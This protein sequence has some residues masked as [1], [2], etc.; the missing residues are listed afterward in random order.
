MISFVKLMLPLTKFMSFTN[1]TNLAGIFPLLSLPPAAGLD[2][3]EEE[4]LLAPRG[5]A[6][7]RLLL[8]P[9]A[10]CELG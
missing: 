1:L 7:D 8:C 2:A 5:L 3:A 6:E 4:G 10:P 9:W